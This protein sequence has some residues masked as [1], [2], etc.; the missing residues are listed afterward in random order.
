MTMDMQPVESTEPQAVDPKNDPQ[1]LLVEKLIAKVKANKKHHKTRFDWMREDMDFAFGRQWVDNTG[2]PAPD[3]DDRYKANIVQRHINQAVASLYAKNPT[4]KVSRRKR[5]DYEVFDGDPESLQEAHMGI[6]GAVE[7][8][9]PPPPAAVDVAM[10]V[11]QAKAGRKVIDNVSRTIELLLDYAMHENRF[12]AQ[13]KQWVRR[14]KTTGVGWCRVGYQREM[15]KQPETQKQINDITKRLAHMDRLRAEVAD[16]Q[17]GDHDA[18]AEKLR[19]MM[20]DLRAQQDVVIREGLVYSWPKSTA[21][22]PDKR[23][24]DLRGLTDCSLLAEEFCYSVDEVQELF[25]VD[26]KAKDWGFTTYSM[27]EKTGEAVATQKAEADEQESPHCLLWQVF[28]RKS[29]LLYTVVDGCPRFLEEP[30]SPNVTL[31]RFFPHFALTFNE[32]EH[33]RE[34]FPPSDVRI[35]RPMQLEYNRVREDVRQQRW[36]NRPAWVAPKGKLEKDDVNA[37]KNYPAHAVVFLQALAQG[38]KVEDVLQRVPV[39]QIDQFA[40]SVAPMFEDVLRTVGSSEANLGGTSGAT[41]TESSIA[42]TSRVDA[43]S[44]NVDDLDSTLE[45]IARASAQVLFGNMKVE[46]VKRLVG[47]G[48]AWPEVTTQETQEE[49]FVTIEAGSSGRPNAAQDAAKFE[50]LFPVLSQTPGVSPRWLAK[51]AI[52][53]IDANVDIDEAYVDGAPSITALNRQAQMGTG[54][55]ETDPNQQGEEGGDNKEKPGER[56]QGPQPAFPAGGAPSP[57]GPVRA[58]GRAA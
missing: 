11:E 58:V 47:P 36:A 24:S 49:I 14:A 22:I 2:K 51:K 53:L 18:E 40:S 38:E 5:L 35:L 21:V 28:E 6:V 16:T 23:C 10:D 4:M 13:A 17:T 25:G 43:V 3:T 41:A 57:Q 30:R 44:S 15:G 26:L 39:A 50:R 34:V 37:L 45:D 55:P 54:N 46:T 48:A 33:E 32:I 9:Q 19:L 1:R 52:Q 7:A 8:G 56:Q 20:Q 29:G 31:E 27:D 42:E 12:K